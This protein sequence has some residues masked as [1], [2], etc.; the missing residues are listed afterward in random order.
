MTDDAEV[1][2]MNSRDIKTE[3]C[4]TLKSTAVMSD[5]IELM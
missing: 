2:R 3:P 4:G 1:Q 5:A